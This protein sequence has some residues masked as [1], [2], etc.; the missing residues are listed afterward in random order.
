MIKA[1]TSVYGRFDILTMEN[2]LLQVKK[3]AG[4]RE[5][6]RSEYFWMENKNKLSGYIRQIKA[7]SG[8]HT[9]LCFAYT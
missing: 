9:T 4:R 6:E 7:R 3:G 8:H 1:Y 2:A 5:K